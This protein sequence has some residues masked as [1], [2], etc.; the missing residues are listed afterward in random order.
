MRGPGIA[1][2]PPHDPGPTGLGRSSVAHSNP[3]RNAVQAKPWPRATAI[4]VPA[5]RLFRAVEPSPTS[6]SLRR[7][8]L[9]STAPGTTRGD[10]SLCSGPTSGLPP[11]R[12]PNHRLGCQRCECRSTL[13]PSTQF[14]C[15]PDATLEVAIRAAPA[16][17]LGSRTGVAL[18]VWHGSLARR[19]KTVV[20][21]TGD[22]RR[23]S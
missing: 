22:C 9:P 13:L 12:S 20:L 16:A 5:V 17:E 23:A 2:H 3:R 8:R 14:I 10:R 19:R 15:Q 4:L 7:F 1:S 6:W 21:I 11:C 18:R